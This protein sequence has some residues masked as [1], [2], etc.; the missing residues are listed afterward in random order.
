[1]LTKERWMK[2]SAVESPDGFLLL[3]EEMEAILLPV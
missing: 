1:M 2:R 3:H